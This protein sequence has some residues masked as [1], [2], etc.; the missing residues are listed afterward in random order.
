VRSTWLLP[1]LAACS[2]D[3]GVG[4]GDGAVVADVRDSGATIDAPPDMRVAS[5][6]NPN[7]PTLVACYPFEG[8]TQDV[9]GHNLNASMTNVMFAAGKVG[10]AMQF[11]AT[12]AADVADSPLFDVAAI[13]IEAWI[14][15]A[16]LPTAGL[17]MGIVDNNGQYGMFLHEQGRI[18]CT[19]VNGASLQVDANIAANTWAHVACTYDG[20]TT[21]YIDG[22]VVGTGSGGT[23]LGTAGTTGISIA[24]DNPPGAGSRLIG[25][26]DEVRISSV[27]RTAAEICVDAQCP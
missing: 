15:P 21:I 16:Q 14:K 11:G 18:A 6:C 9:S 26:I 8:S 19:M 2:F 12:S 4:L 5:S 13:T 7:D 17:R 25:L 3:H 23:A 1:A 27:A 22:R 20:T 24:A 10:Q